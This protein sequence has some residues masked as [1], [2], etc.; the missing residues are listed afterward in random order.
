LTTL[1]SHNEELSKEKEELQVLANYLKNDV[2]TAFVK[3]MN[4]DPLKNPV[5]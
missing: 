5:D 1:E 4:T 2:I 3:R